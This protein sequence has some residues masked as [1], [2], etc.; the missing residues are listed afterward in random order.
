MKKSMRIVMALLLMCCLT[1]TTVACGGCNGSETGQQGEMT[2]QGQYDLGIRLL[3]EGDYE[4]AIL[5][6]Q[7]AIQIDPKRVDAYIGMAD[8]YLAMNDPQAAVDALSQGWN[9]V[10]DS[11]RTTLDDKQQ[12]IK[13]NHPEVVIDND[14]SGEDG[15]DGSNNGNAGNDAA[16][17]EII[18]EMTEYIDAQFDYAGEFHE[19][20]AVVGHTQDDGNLAYYYIDTEGTVIAGPYDYAADFCEGRAAVGVRTEVSQD[21]WYGWYDCYY[22]GYIDASG[23]EVVPL[24][25]LLDED[26]TQ[27]LSYYNGLAEVNWFSD[28]YDN[29]VW[30]NLI[31][32]DGNK[33]L[34]ADIL[35]VDERGYGGGEEWIDYRLLDMLAPAK[36]AWGTYYCYNAIQQARY[37][38]NNNGITRVYTGT[39]TLWLDKNMEIIDSRFGCVYQLSEDPVLYAIYD[40]SK[41]NYAGSDTKGQLVDDSGN[42]ILEGFTDCQIW[43]D[44]YLYVE[45]IE[46]GDDSNPWG[47]STYEM[48]TL[49]GTPFDPGY[50]IYSVTGEGYLVQENYDDNSG[51][52]DWIVLDRNFVEVLTVRAR[53]VEQARTYIYDN[54]SWNAMW[55][56]MYQI[57]DYADGQ[58]IQYYVDVNGQRILDAAYDGEQRLDDALECIIGSD[59]DTVVLCDY[60]GSVLTALEGIN[61]IYSE[62]YAGVENLYRGYLYD[63]ATG[64][65]GESSYYQITR[66]GGALNVIKVDAAPMDGEYGMV[67]LKED[68][69]TEKVIRKNAV[70]ALI[71]LAY[72]IEIPL[73]LEYQGNVLT[74]S[75]A[76]SLVSNGLYKTGG[77]VVYDEN[78]WKYAVNDVSLHAAEG[79][80]NSVVY[81]DMGYL[82]ENFISFRIGGKWGYLKVIQ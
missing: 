75:A 63:S 22:Y 11:D 24:Q 80:W 3:N 34:P 57:Y 4:N 19:G 77:S 73:T 30:T 61:H 47:T 33:V 18:L 12:E 81:E 15:P 1:C 5:A 67:V 64:N 66:N 49:D 69:T 14:G 74:Q 78:S 10:S 28:E 21:A 62:S 37:Q 55:L 43:H 2:W 70:S 7:A 39:E 20:R 51:T 25:Y 59:E 56:P 82:S 72:N 71:G 8:V 41:T 40:G 36:R 45:Y 42:V 16:S 9:A 65:S 23:N 60:D 58:N 52:A 6:F 44:E 13:K 35:V 17:D 48:Y 79:G 50:E 76:A 31:D 54:D 27:G 46:P 38:G 29:H 26:W 53:G 32:K 68:L